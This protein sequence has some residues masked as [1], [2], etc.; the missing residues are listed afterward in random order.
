MLFR[1][2]G[3]YLTVDSI[4]AT[5]TAYNQAIRSVAANMGIILVDGE[6][7]IPG[8]SRHFADSVHFRDPGSKLMARRVS[9]SLLA[10]QPF[11]ELVQRKNHN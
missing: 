1:A 11:Q 2:I 9:K 10:A 5:M 3:S 7:T 6:D 4:L 8:D